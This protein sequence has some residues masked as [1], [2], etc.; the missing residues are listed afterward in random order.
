MES[1]R[2]AQQWGEGFATVEYLAA[3]LLDQAWH[4]LSPDDE[5][6][7][8]VAFEAAA[9]ADAGLDLPLIRRVPQP[10]FQHI[11][12]GGYSAGYYS[13]IWSEVLDADTVDMIT[14]N[15]GLTGPTVTTCARR[16]CRSAGRSRPWTPSERCADGTPTSSRSCGDGVST[17][18][19]DAGA[20]V[21]AG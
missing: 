14:E 19:G 4:R 12:D 5:V 9:L 20:R 18:L 21:T 3:T 2:A 11:F 17:A 6:S 16:C 7:D 13:Y 8:V 1:I 10:Y 15:G